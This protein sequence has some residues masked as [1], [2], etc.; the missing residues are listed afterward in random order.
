[1]TGTELFYAFLISIPVCWGITFIMMIGFSIWEDR[2]DDKKEKKWR[3]CAYVF[4]RNCIPFILIQIFANYILLKFSEKGHWAYAI[5]Y[6]FGFLKAIQ[7]FFKDDA[8]KVGYFMENLDEKHVKM[9]VV[10]AI[11]AFFQILFFIF[12]LIYLTFKG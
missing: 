6:A 3:N 1:M 4:Y 5:A 2:T 7:T 11:L 12:M 9:M 8:K 10:T